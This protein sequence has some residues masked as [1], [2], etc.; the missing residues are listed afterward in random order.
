MYDAFENDCVIFTSVLKE[1]NESCKKYVF[2]LSVITFLDISEVIYFT[3]IAN[4]SY[5]S[6]FLF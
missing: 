2:I 1:K 4:F 6:R 3:S 5:F